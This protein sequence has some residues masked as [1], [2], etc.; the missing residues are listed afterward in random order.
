MADNFSVSLID[1]IYLLHT[2]AVSK[3]FRH[4]IY[5]LDFVFF[6][7]ANLIIC[8]V[9]WAGPQST[10]MFLRNVCHARFGTSR[11]DRPMISSSPV[12]TN[13]E[14]SLRC[15]RALGRPGPP[16][17]W[18]PAGTPGRCIPADSGGRWTAWSAVVQS[19]KT[20][21]EREERDRITYSSY[22]RIYSEFKAR[23]YPPF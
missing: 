9:C 22:S 13:S 12:N 19:R 11:P 21:G 5:L 23:L 20:I 15:R 8:V 10:K 14:R 2:W 17:D 4:P 1:L 6:L 7:K 16:V 3:F 18:P